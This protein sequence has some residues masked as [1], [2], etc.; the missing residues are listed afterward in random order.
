MQRY[1]AVFSQ[2]G[3]DWRRANDYQ[4]V[5]DSRWKFLDIYIE[6]YIDI[7]FN[8]AGQPNGFKKLLL[9]RHSLPFAPAFEIQI[10]KKSISSDPFNFNPGQIA[11]EC[12]SYPDGIYFTIP[13]WDSGFDG[14]TVRIRGM[15]RVYDLDLRETYKAPSS[16]LGLAQPSPNARYGA[17]F[18]DPNRGGTNI[19]ESDPRKYTLYTP[20]KQISVHISGVFQADD[21]LLKVVH[22]VGYPPSY[23]LCSAFD[24][25]GSPG[26]NIIAPRGQFVYGALFESYA[27]ARANARD[28][29]FTGVQSSLG[30]RKFGCVILK[31]PA[32][33]AG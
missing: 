11:Q 20:A 33:L 2:Q 29:S 27:N 21:G 22:D 18:L 31:D 3:I 12:Y 14:P 6:K 5:M 15:L 30:D 19:N 32:E 10:S 8:L 13:F 25:N 24:E 28:I 7:T 16:V 17:K 23:L 9:W 1:G 26:S 4:K